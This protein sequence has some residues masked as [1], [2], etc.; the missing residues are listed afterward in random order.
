MRRFTTAAVILIA[1]SVYAQQPADD[2][3]KQ[4]YRFGE[5]EGH[6]A[7]QV[8][9]AG[10]LRSLTVSTANAPLSVTGGNDSG[11]TITVCK[12]AMRQ[13]DLDAIRVTVEG[14]ELRATGPDGRKWSISYKIQAPSGGDVR[15]ETAN[16]P[17]SI[18]DY[19]GALTARTTNGPVSLTNV[20]GVTDV[21]TA[22]GPVS[23]TGSSGT[24]K[25]KASNGPLSVTLS[26]THWAG[27]SLEASTENGPLTLKMPSNYASG[28][29]AGALGRGPISCQAAGCERFRDALSITRERRADEPRRI[30]LGNGAAAVHV[31]TRNGPVS[32]RE[33]G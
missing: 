10:N 5:K 18:R 8:I 29:V 16:G 7:R 23:I 13:E 3:S 28:V 22:N 21:T 6:V 17:V 11:Y 20:S 26:G 15:L 30:E 33:Q 12:A 19:D 27:G 32:I 14:G 2:C 9:E 1:G 4:H 24:M 25:V 31:T